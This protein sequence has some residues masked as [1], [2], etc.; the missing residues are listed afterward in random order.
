MT[1]TW[2][3]FSSAKRYRCLPDFGPTVGTCSTRRRLSPIIWEAEPTGIGSE[4]CRRRPCT[5]TAR[6]TRSFGSAACLAA[7][8]VDFRRQVVHDRAK[9]G[10]VDPTLLPPQW[11]EEERDKMM[12]EQ[13]L[14]DVASWAGK[15]NTEALRRQFP[16]ASSGMAGGAVA[17]PPAPQRASPRASP[18]TARA[19]EL[20]LVR[21]QALQARL[22]GAT[23][24]DE[25]A[26][27]A[28]EEAHLELCRAFCALG[29]VEAA[30]GDEKRA[31]EAFARALEHAKSAQEAAPTG[32]EGDPSW[33]GAVAQAIAA[34]H[35][36]A[37][38][39]V[40][41]KAAL[42]EAL[43]LAAKALAARC[44]EA[45]EQL[46]HD[47]VEC[48][49]AAHEQTDDRKGLEVFVRGLQNVLNGLKRDAGDLAPAAVPLLTGADAAPLGTAGGV[50]AKLLE[51]IAL[52]CVATGR[53]KDHELVKKVF[54]DFRV[55]RE[56]PGLRRLLGMLQSSGTFLDL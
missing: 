49:H 55:A 16:A 45:S 43:P 17:A 9:N 3:I 5:L 47:V 25:A 7:H 10:G 31:A 42:K 36:G 53:E 46:A 4:K 56:S 12:K 26:G 1:H 18:E 54:T 11:A 39:Y 30:A 48:V 27:A 14:Q 41:A 37:R 52:I 51:R 32:R 50:R 22:H 34:V 13:Q 24:A 19:R 29:Q 6:G 33:H 40:E 21:I 38:R 20:T 23:A 28:P 35:M 44:D 8:G 2:N 15:G